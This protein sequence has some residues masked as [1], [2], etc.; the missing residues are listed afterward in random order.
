MKGLHSK[1]N[2]TISII[3]IPEFPIMIS[4]IITELAQ[5]HI[6]NHSKYPDVVS[7]TKTQI[8]HYHRFPN[9]EKAHK[10]L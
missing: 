1:H 10:T 4:M 6:N 7:I 9:V 8:E 2:N 3:Y 5:I